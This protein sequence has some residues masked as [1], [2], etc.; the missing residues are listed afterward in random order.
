M[1]S[2]RSSVGRP[3]SEFRGGRRSVAEVSTFEDFHGFVTCDHIVPISLD[4]VAQ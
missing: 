2:R 3:M 1:I 4:P